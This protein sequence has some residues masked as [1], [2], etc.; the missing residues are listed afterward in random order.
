MSFEFPMVYWM[1]EKKY[2]NYDKRAC[3]RNINCRNYM[4]MAWADTSSIG[5]ARKNCSI[6]REPMANLNHKNSVYFVCYYY[7]VYLNN[8]FLIENS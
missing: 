6:L 5:C 2:F 3:A 8:S 4:Q 1:S 7:S